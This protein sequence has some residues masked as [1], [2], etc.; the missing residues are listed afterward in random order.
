MRFILVFIF[1]FVG[2]SS[3]NVVK[4]DPEPDTT[5]IGCPDSGK[6]DYWPL[7][8]GNTWEYSYSYEGEQHTPNGVKQ[9]SESATIQVK[10]IS[11]LKTNDTTEVFTIESITNGKHSSVD[12]RRTTNS[13]GYAYYSSGFKRSGSDSILTILSSGSSSGYSNTN[14]KYK[15]GVG[16]IEEI[17]KSFSHI[18]AGNEI[19][20][21]RTTKLVKYSLKN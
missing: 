9:L 7:A 13:I 5:C 20:A 18:T 2:L 14:T 3:C 10:T 4:S 8:V 1:L 12:I 21:T 11:Y 19:Y 16:M 6:Q 15:K 17:E